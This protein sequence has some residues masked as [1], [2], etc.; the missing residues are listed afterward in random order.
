MRANECSENEKVLHNI[1]ETDK[2]DSFLLKEMIFKDSYL[3]Q[4]DGRCDLKEDLDCVLWQ[5]IRNDLFK[6]KDVS[7]L[8]MFKI[9]F[10]F[11]KNHV[12]LFLEKNNIS[13]FVIYD[14]ELFINIVCDNGKINFISGIYL[15]SF[16][17]DK[18]LDL[19]W[20]DY[21]TNIVNNIQ[22]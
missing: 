2:F 5:M 19:I 4:I 10:K 6:G 11:K 9:V 21:V 20:D 22:G 8:K 18:T 12:R 16:I 3:V 15:N 17:N 1:F 7:N 14:P 13:S